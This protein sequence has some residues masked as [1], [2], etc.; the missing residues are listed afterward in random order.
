MKK[1]AS[2]V[3]LSKIKLNQI[4]YYINFL[5]SKKIDPLFLI[6]TKNGQT[7]YSGS[8][9]NYVDKQDQALFDPSTEQG[10]IIS[11]LNDNLSTYLQSYFKDNPE[12][13]Q[14]ISDTSIN[15]YL[16]YDKIKEVL[17]S[18]LSYENY[19]ILKTVLSSKDLNQTSLLS[20]TLSDNDYKILCQAIVQCLDYEKVLPLINKAIMSLT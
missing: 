4:Q 8:V 17:L 10:S 7:I 9:V 16:T 1:I 5:I 3:P 12:I 20:K 14:Q 18:L 2:Y 11:Y 19:S 15:S 6:Q 13:L